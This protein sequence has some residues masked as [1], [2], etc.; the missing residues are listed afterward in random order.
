MENEIWKDVEGYKGYYQVSN[1]GNVK[2][3]KKKKERILKP[4]IDKQGY[5]IVYLC[6]EN[7]KVNTSIHRLVASN[8]L[9]ASNLCVNHKNGNKLDNR[10]ENLEFVTHREN[11]THHKIMNNSK[12]SKFA[13]VCWHKRDKK[14][15]S[16]VY[17]NGKINNLGS[18]DNELDAY[19]AYLKAL[20]ENGITNKYA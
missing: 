20:Q 16:Q 12:N 5:K 9:G 2:S 18:F 11:I 10:V 19:N 1:L 17:I 15:T 8:F 3:F 6:L 4:F 13:G 14:W 7:G